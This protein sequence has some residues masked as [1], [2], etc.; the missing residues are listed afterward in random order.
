MIQIGKASTLPTTNASEGIDSNNPFNTQGG[1]SLTTGFNSQSSTR[2]HH[3]SSASTSIVRQ[4]AG[5]EKPA[6]S[7]WDPNLRATGT[8]FTREFGEHRHSDNQGPSLQSTLNLPTSSTLSQTSSAYNNAPNLNSSGQVSTGRIESAYAKN[9]RSEEREHAGLVSFENNYTEQPHHTLSNFPLSRPPIPQGSTSSTAAEIALGLTN[10]YNLQAEQMNQ[11]QMGSNG[12]TRNRAWNTVGRKDQDQRPIVENLSE[13]NDKDTEDHTSRTSDTANTS[14][15]ERMKPMH[16]SSDQE[17][18][19]VPRVMIGTPSTVSTVP[20]TDDASLGNDYR[21]DDSVLPHLLHPGHGHRRGNSGASWGEELLLPGNAMPLSPQHRVDRN[22]PWSQ[23]PSAHHSQQRA[24]GAVPRGQQQQR[25]ASFRQGNERNNG[26]WSQEQS[27]H[28]PDQHSQ[29]YFQPPHLRQQQGYF[30]NRNYLPPKG[31]NARPNG[32]GMVVNTPPR[33]ARAQRIPQGGQP[34][35]QKQLTTPSS[36]HQAPVPSQQR[37]SSEI[38]KTLLRKKACLYEPDTSRAVALV[39]WLVGRELAIEYGFFSRQQLQSG[40]HACVAS[41]IDGGIITR[42]KVNRCMQIILNSCF[43]YI[44]PRSDGTEEK[45]DYFREG[46]AQT[47]KDDSY[48]LKYLSRLWNDVTVDRETVLEASLDDVEEKPSHSNKVASTPKTSPKLTS[49]D[50]AKSPPRISHHNDHFESKRAV[51]LC[52]NENVRSAEDVFRS[53]NEFIRDTANAVHLQLTAQEWR[54]FFGREAGHGQHLLGRVGIPMSIQDAPGGPD[55]L[56]RM[57]PEEAAKFRTSWCT[58]RYEHDHELCGFAHV[59]ISN[60]W[61]RRNPMTYPYTDEM[62][63]FVTSCS[64]DKLGRFII[65][66]CPKGLMCDKAHSKEEMIYHP[67]RYKCKVCPSVLS[68]SGACDFGDVCPH[69]HPEDKAQPPKKPSE[70]AVGARHGKKVEQPATVKSTTAPP[71]A[72][73]VVYAS[74]APLSSFE[75]HLM[76][77]GLQNLYRR[78]SSVVRA[79]VR[80]SGKFTCRYSSFG[81]DLGISVGS[82]LPQEP[83][84]GLPPGRR[85]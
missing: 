52:F 5:F 7:S 58:K 61:L 62:C 53:H 82:D 75:T 80:S 9:H 14:S 73:P 74:P 12:R 21:L 85:S 16:D 15:P 49:V 76:M 84:S 19:E 46:F 70:V 78:N 2:G 23:Q 72:S 28:L 54:T 64:D 55:L 18:S 59:E 51:L 6:Q 50:P 1:S 10:S 68:Q 25:V 44:I 34:T 29:Q 24:W 3:E 77:P 35:S 26:A 47:V 4:T 40:V 56:G 30:Q 65:N 31:P 39:T 69:L 66:E 41:K 67:N 37:S 57:V 71:T 79:H 22:T 20:S 60:G 83:H 42:T 27:G 43:H 48:L 13:V 45:G 17:A 32:V 36:P 33:N 81:D 8:D 63:Q 38:L 11:H